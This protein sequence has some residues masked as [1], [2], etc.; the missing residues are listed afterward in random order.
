M[1]SQALKAFPRTFGFIPFS[2]LSLEL[3]HVVWPLLAPQPT[4]ASCPPPPPH[5]HGKIQGLSSPRACWAWGSRVTEAGSLFSGT[6][7]EAQLGP[8]LGSSKS[9]LGCLGPDPS[10]L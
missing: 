2:L 9:L 8:D 10:C 5:Y 4:L 3:I 1:D 7:G 6:D